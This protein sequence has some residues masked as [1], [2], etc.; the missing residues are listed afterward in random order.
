MRRILVTGG[1]GQVG[2]ELARQGWPADVELLLPMRE[3]LD[4]GSA[5]SVAAFFAAHELAAVINPAAYTAVDKAESESEAAFLANA[6][7]PKLLAEASARAGIPIVHVSTDYVFDGTKD[8]PYVESDPVAPLGVY[9]ASKLEGE[10]TIAAGNPR[11]VI[12][13][14]AWVLSA[15]RG[16]FLKTM[17]R[18][19]ATNPK[20]RVVADQIG[21]PTSA[22]DIAEAL[23]IITLRLIEDERAPTGTYH[24]VNAGE[25]SWHDLATEIFRLS[26]RSGG[27]APQVEAITTAEYPTPAKRPANSRLSTAKITADY[28]IHPRDWRAGVRDIIDELAGPVAQTGA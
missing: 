19:G 6:V 18:V 25:A 12:L 2:I 22:H 5:E 15:H 14:T 26:A 21:C 11:S 13:R 28:G 17:L 7:G 24:F 9:G 20:L 1:A 10:Q 4:I 3:E 27:A 16:N 8:E 23:R